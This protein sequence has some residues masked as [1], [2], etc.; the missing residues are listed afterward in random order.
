[1]WYELRSSGRED[2]SC[3]TSGTR[4]VTLV[5]NSGQVMNEEMTEKCLRKV[6]ICDTEN[7]VM[8]LVIP[9]C[10]CC[11]ESDKFVVLDILIKDECC[12]QNIIYALHTFQ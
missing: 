12:V 9:L 6:V 11:D 10:T 2:S 3:S 8:M 5:A 7:H 1:M 4:R